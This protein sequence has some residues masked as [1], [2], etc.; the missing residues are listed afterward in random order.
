MRRGDIYWIDFEPA[1]GSEANKR[2]PAVVVS[3]NENNSYVQSTGLGTITVLPI[4]TNTRFV[5]SFHV[6]VSSAESG[7]PQE[8]KIQAEQIRTVSASRVG[9][10]IGSLSDRSMWQVDM[11]IRTHLAL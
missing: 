6:L 8:S 2:R 9:D 4:T 11:A 7:L 3:R 10:F 1:Q 5:A